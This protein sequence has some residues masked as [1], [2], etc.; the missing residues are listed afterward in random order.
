MCAA[1]LVDEEKDVAASKDYT[2]DPGA[3]GHPQICHRGGGL[4]T[5]ERCCSVAATA[6][7]AAS[8]ASAEVQASS[9]EALSV[10]QASPAKDCRAHAV[11]DFPA[12]LPTRE[13]GSI[14]TLVKKEGDCVSS[15]TLPVMKRHAMR[16]DCAGETI[17][18]IA[19]DKATNDFESLDDGYIAKFQ[20]HTEQRISSWVSQLPS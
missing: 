6:A 8:I 18:A 5:E 14:G 17:C 7:A 19:T 1:I 4:L 16:S 9:T 12:M 2:H 13:R 15:G 20:C 11:V 10:T 3:S